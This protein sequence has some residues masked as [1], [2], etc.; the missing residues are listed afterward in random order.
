MINWFSRRNTKEKINQ[1]FSQYVSSE[2]IEA[3]NS[4][5]PMELNVLS[6]GP[7]EFVFAVVQ[8]STANETAQR[9]GVVATIAHQNGWIVQGFLCNLVLLVNGVLPVKERLVLERTSL[10]DK[11]LQ[12]MGSNIKIVHGR[13]TA[14]FGNMGSAARISYGVLLPSF[15]EVLSVLNTL[16]YG[17]SHE[18]HG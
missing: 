11:L 6:E 4:S 17:R 2:M 15:P 8:G 5:K 13:E 10:T 7:V 12:S 18:Y 14:P 1:L 9:L 16:P 3:V